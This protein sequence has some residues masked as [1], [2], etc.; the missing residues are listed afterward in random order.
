MKP[1]RINKQGFIRR[2]PDIL[3]YFVF[4]CNSSFIILLASLLNSLQKKRGTQECDHCA[5]KKNREIVKIKLQTC[6]VHVHQ[7]KSA[8]EMCKGKQFGDVTNALRQ[9]FEWRERSR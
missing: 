6:A 2:L 1:M 8:A 9:L 5:G 4:V 3:F 7:S